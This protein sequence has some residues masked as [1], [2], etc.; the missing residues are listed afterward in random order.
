LRHKKK[1]T[2]T[3]ECLSS[4]RQLL[5]MSL[6]SSSSASKK[7]KVKVKKRSGADTE[8]LNT[9][10][11]TPPS[12]AMPTVTAFT[13]Q[14]LPLP[15]LPQPHGGDGTEDELTSTSSS[16]AAIDTRSEPSQSTS[17][18]AHGVEAPRRRTANSAQPERA[19][20]AGSDSGGGLSANDRLN[21]AAYAVFERPTSAASTTSSSSSSSKIKKKAAKELLKAPAFAAPGVPKTKKK[22]PAASGALP[23]AG[24]RD[25]RV[26]LDE[27]EDDDLS[28][29]L[30]RARDVPPQFDEAPDYDDNESDDSE[31]T[32][33]R[34]RTQ[35]GVAPKRGGG[36]GGGDDD[37]DDEVDMMSSSLMAK[38]KLARSADR[39][40][41]DGP[42]LSMRI[43]DAASGLHCNE[44][45]VFVADDHQLFLHKQAVHR[46]Q[47]TA[48]PPPA[49][50][51]KSPPPTANNALSPRTRLRCGLCKFT[52]FDNDELA[53]HVEE[54]EEELARDKGRDVETETLAAL[55]GLSRAVDVNATPSTVSR[56]VAAPDRARAGSTPLHKA[57][58]LAA[59]SIAKAPP[60]TAGKPRSG[61]TKLFKR[62]QKSEL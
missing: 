56:L 59:E 14:S 12:H 40:P 55:Y 51:K 60:V 44:C 35:Y 16:L 9:P 54:H 32:T 11:P 28:T 46:N 42:P 31:G 10:L 29:M 61:T 26:P 23:R 43:G 38:L 3:V 62:S 24:A 1:I 15:P 25:N 18:G 34:L 30:S 41:R 19:D 45:G 52:C 13:L 48:S 37:D 7:V 39:A 2:K 33:V 6:A 20:T 57:G 17:P 50:A 22:S 27:D 49:A 36:G 5:S 21:L 58:S 53:R 8:H 4:L 47:P